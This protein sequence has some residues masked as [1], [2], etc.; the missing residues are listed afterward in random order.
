MHSLQLLFLFKDKFRHL[1]FQN[2]Q[3]IK[4]FTFIEEF[5][6]NNLHF[7]IMHFKPYDLHF[8]MM[9]FKNW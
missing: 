9:D 3:F 8:Q 5:N 6:P 1:A 2:F 4:A 7:Q